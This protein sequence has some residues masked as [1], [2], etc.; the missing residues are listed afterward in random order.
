MARQRN[1]ELAAVHAGIGDGHVPRIDDLHAPVFA[2]G[3]YEIA[4]ARAPL[5]EK[6]SYQELL[7]GIFIFRYVLAS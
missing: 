1:A 3:L 7:N 4:E 6:K 2:R 5:S